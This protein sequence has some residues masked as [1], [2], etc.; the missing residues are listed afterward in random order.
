[1]KPE[2]SFDPAG[3]VLYVRAPGARLRNSTEAPSD[4]YLILNYDDTGAVVGL[5]VLAASELGGCWS[6]HPDRRLVPDSL[7]LAIDHWLQ[8][9]A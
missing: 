6:T 7:A 9:H 1:M 3:D 2:V 5:Q 8:A 4:S